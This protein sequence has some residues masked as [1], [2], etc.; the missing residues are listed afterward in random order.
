MGELSKWSKAVKI[1]MIKQDLT[2][3]DVA[4]KLHKT[5][6]Y[7]SAIVNGRLYSAPTIKDISDLLNIPD[8]K[9]TLRRV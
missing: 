2:I 3:T 8:A 9:D 1:E 6:P 5:R 4:V 7:I